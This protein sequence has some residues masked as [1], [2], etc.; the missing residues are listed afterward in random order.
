LRLISMMVHCND[1]CATMYDVSWA[2]VDTW[3]CCQ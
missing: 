1:R 2:A 3:H